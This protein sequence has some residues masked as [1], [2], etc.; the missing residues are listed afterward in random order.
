MVFGNDI[1]KGKDYSN[2]LGLVNFSVS[3][4]VVIPRRR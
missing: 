1:N 4:Y 2:Q 3:F